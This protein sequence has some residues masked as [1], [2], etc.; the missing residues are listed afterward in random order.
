MIETI[1][2]RRLLVGFSALIVLGLVVLGTSTAI[3]WIKHP[4]GLGKSQLAKAQTQAV[5]NGQQATS[6]A[7][8]AAI[9]DSRASNIARIHKTAQEARHAVQQSTDHDDRLRQYLDGLERVRR[10]GAAPITADPADRGGH[11][12]RR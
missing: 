7:A 9:N 8:G 4:F 3:D 2:T 5:V 1:P 6:N 11:D 10:D 12:P